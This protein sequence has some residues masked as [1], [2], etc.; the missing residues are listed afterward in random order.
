MPQQPL[1][2]VP[3]DATWE[4]QDHGACREADTALFFHTQNERGL[5]VLQIG[6]GTSTVISAANG[7]ILCQTSQ[8]SCAI[9]GLTHKTKYTVSVTGFTREGNHTPSQ[10][11]TFTTK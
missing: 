1:A 4:W 5:S 10:N 3:L 8:L 9:T 2:Q 7:S 11:L 6:N